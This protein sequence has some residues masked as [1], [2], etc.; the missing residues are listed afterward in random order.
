MTWLR[1][2]KEIVRTGLTIER[3]RLE[4]LVALRAAAG[5][6]IV[7]GLALWLVS[8][9]YAASTAFGAFSAG[10]ATFQRSWR[11]RKVIALAAGVGLALSTFLGYLAAGHIVPF[12]LLLAAWS[13][14]AGMAW[15]AGPT[16]GI[17]ATA[18][19][20]IMLVTI[21]LPTSVEQALEHAVV[22]ALG[23]VVQATLILLFPIRRW[24]A[25]RDALADAFAGVAD[26]ARRLR[27]DPTATFDPEPMM[28]ARDAAAV[29]PA[30]ARRR[31][32]ALHGPRGLAERI[33][34]VVAALADPQVGAPAE[35]PE[36]DRVRELLAAAADVLDAAARSIRRG[37]PAPVRPQVMEV[38][39]IDEEHEV[40]EGPAR[41]AAVQLVSLLGEVL[42]TAESGG[43]PVTPTTAPGAGDTPPL[44]RPTIFRQVPVV[45]REMRSEL[46]RDSPIMRHAVRLAAV[47]SLGYLLGT[48]LP[49]GH[50]YWA[51][52]ASVMVLR[53]DF[54]QTYARAVG[55][56]AGTLVGVALAT[57]VV[58]LAHPDASLSG[59]LAV[60][61]AAL[62][63][64]LMRTGYAV[65]QCFTA[66]YVVFLLGMGGEGWHQTVRD[67]VLLTLLGGAL[68]MLAYLV[69]P[70]WETP[71]L[72]DRLADWLAANGRYAAAVVRGY[73]DPAGRRRADVRQALLASRA[74]NAAWRKALDRAKQE[75]VR[76]RGLTRRQAED[77]DEAVES[78][79]RAAMLLET[80]LPERGARPNPEAA[81]FAEA[82]EADTAQAARDMRERRNP[83]WD[84]VEEALDAWE[85]AE[86]ALDPVARLGAEL[87]VQALEELATAVGRTPLER[88]IESSRLERQE[89]AE[90]EEG[91]RREGDTGPAPP[92]KDEG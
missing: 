72:L 45:L 68:A 42:E 51:P 55:R 5:V 37:V 4:P 77:A 58:Q 43:M 69:F 36:R 3:T 13:F 35:G 33:R 6:A 57:G 14:L 10:T 86:S 34:P 44:L 31:P 26:Y 46:H 12:L 62:T 73:A 59:G 50:G 76:H 16:A 71:R 20:G 2:L 52:I 66:A 90:K 87:Q 22:I 49:L 64:L 88:D 74:A 1:A 92:P 70:A 65:S 8:P 7:I 82:L 79:G 89:R 25:H 41:Q 67:R 29:T 47:A 63:Y 21:T 39:R 17:V 23:G 80:H 11:P 61:S 56:F 48:W 60:V 24:G 30:Q 40:L 38:L 19:V 81:R 28:T 75:P 91:S 85:G 27:H 78:L 83:D 54:H 18:T 9:A 84:R 53:P 32:A 15:A